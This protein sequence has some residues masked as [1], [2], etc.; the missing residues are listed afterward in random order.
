MLLLIQNRYKHIS[1]I[2]YTFK[3]Q[4]DSRFSD[5]PHGDEVEDD[6]RDNDGHRD[7]GL[8]SDLGGENC[9]IDQRKL[10]IVELTK[11]SK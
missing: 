6:G 3:Y 10:H 4:F 9:H 7:D 2:L 5:I 8:N 11:S 1:F